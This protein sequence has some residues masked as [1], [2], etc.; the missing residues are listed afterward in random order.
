MVQPLYRHAL[1]Q[2]SFISRLHPTT[3]LIA[4][5]SFI[6]MVFSTLDLRIMTAMLAFLIGVIVSN[7][8]PARDTFAVLYV[9][10]PMA[11]FIMMLQALLRDTNIVFSREVLGIGIHL[12]GDG[13][14]LGAKIAFRI[15]LLAVAVSIFFV[16]VDPARLTRALYELGMPFK[17]AYLVTL[18][19]R[20][21]PLIIDEM[22]TITN[23]QK[24][25]GYDIDRSNFLVRGFKV[26]PLMIPLI[27][28]S[29]RRADSI[30]LAMDLRAFGASPQRTFYVEIQRRPIDLVIRVIAV[31][32]A[33]I[34]V[35]RAVLGLFGI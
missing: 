19:L 10:V 15:L 20:F 5:L 4:L 7:H 32:V 9:L 22:R 13:L 26:V 27:V 16:A 17:F 34:F 6:V 33:A 1:K 23:A 14:V 24:S 35:I 12:S 3:V 21:L 29:L 25:R 18:G 28:L 8:L 2:T 30:A 31:A 11:F